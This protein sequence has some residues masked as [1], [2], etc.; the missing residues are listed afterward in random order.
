MKKTFVR[1]VMTGIAALLV[2]AGTL[3]A[4][5]QP[6]LKGTGWVLSGLPGRTL[7]A[8][9]TATI[10]FEA[11]R[12]HGT[13]GCNRYSSGV[14]TSA[15]AIR[16]DPKAASTQMACPQD[17]TDQASAFLGALAR[18][19]AWRMEG[20]NLQLLDGAVVVAT[21]EP[22]AKTL[23][24][25]AWSVTGYN[26]GKQAVASVLL[27]TTLGFAFADDGKV[28]GSAG[29][30]RFTGTFTSKGE[31]LSFGPLATTRKACPKPE[32]IMEQ[33]QQ[34]LTALGTVA[35]ARLEGDRLEL[36]AKDG[37]LAVSA[38]KDSQ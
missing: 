7:V 6:S 27:D 34:F 14:T 24:G 22:Q 29:C 33:E 35:T 19:K 37:A 17:V 30:N 21:F 26:N 31:A 36:R 9:A 10:R 12:A 2:A 11:D 4:S 25:T 1:C 13:D 28:A 15:A 8:E 5:D 20:R 23:A 16:F 3:V 38:R 32:G 18:A